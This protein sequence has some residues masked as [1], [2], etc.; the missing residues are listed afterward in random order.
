MQDDEN[1]EVR[2]QTPIGWVAIGYSADL[3]TASV[4]AKAHATSEHTIGRV[5]DLT[6]NDFRISNVVYEYVGPPPEREPWEMDMVSACQ[7]DD[8]CDWAAD[9]F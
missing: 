1:Y 4:I 2:L 6:V 8:G 7:E 9:G 5:I 3:T